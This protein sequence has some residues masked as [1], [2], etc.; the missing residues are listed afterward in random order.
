MNKRGIFAGV[1]AAVLALSLP[2]IAQQTQPERP[3][4]RPDD[5]LSTKRAPDVIRLEGRVVNVTG[6]TVSPLVA[7]AKLG[8]ARERDSSVRISNENLAKTGPG[9][10]G[11][12]GGKPVAELPA[13]PDSREIIARHDNEVARWQRGVREAAQRV[14]SLETQLQQLEREAGTLEERIG[15]ED[16]PSRMEALAASQP[17]VHQRLEQ[18]RSALAAER[19]R[20]S[21]LAGDRPRLD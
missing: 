15:N 9:L 11:M 1:A 10:V 7:A 21:E 20:A 14:E 17:Q 8:K 16:D 4:R 3:E 6:G 5:E 13:A 12:T 2:L 18:T 19:Q